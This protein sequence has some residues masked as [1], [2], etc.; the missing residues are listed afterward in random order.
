MQEK[1]FKNK[2]L[3]DIYEILYK[4]G[5]MINSIIITPYEDAYNVII[6]MYSLDEDEKGDS[7]QIIKDKIE[8]YFDL[9]EINLNSINFISLETSKPTKSIILKYI[10]VLSPVSLDCLVR[11]LDSDGYKIE[12]KKNINKKL[13]LLRKNNLILRQNDGTYAPTE[14]ALRSIPSGKYRKSTDVQRI[15]ALRRKKW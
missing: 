10:K 6:D 5:D 8:K 1:D 2:I 7:C 14:K 11:N 12:S 3:E 15:L 4:Y 13:D 9:Y